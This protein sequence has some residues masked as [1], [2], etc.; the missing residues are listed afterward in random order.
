VEK[1]GTSEQKQPN[2]QPAEAKTKR[3]HSS[4]KKTKKRELA[5]RENRQLH[6]VWRPTPFRL[7]S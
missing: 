1:R 7:A 3:K 4:G 6:A 5:N 2:E